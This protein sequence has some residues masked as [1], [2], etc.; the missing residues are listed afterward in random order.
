MAYPRAICPLQQIIILSLNNKLGLTSASDCNYSVTL[1][2][3]QVC[4][5]AVI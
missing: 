5:T 4:I 1:L 3:V 2:M